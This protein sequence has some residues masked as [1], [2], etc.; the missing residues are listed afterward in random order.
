MA[1]LNNLYPPIVDT[2]APAFL[3]DSASS[4]KNTC[5]IYFSISLYNSYSDIKNAQITICNQ[6][7]NASVLNEEK[8]P[9]DIML[10][11]IYEDRER[12]SDDKYYVEI[13]KSDMINETFEINQYYKVQIRFTSIDAE[14]INIS[15]PQAIDSWLAANQG[16]FSEWSTICLVRGISTPTISIPGFD[17][18]AD[19][20]IWTTDSINVAGKVTFLNE[21]ETETLKSYRILLYNDLDELISDSDLI[22]TNNYVNVNEINYIFKY[23]FQDGETYHMTIEYTTNNLYSDSTTFTFMV[24][25]GTTGKM[26]ATLTAVEDIENGRIGINIKSNTVDKFTGNLTIRRTSSENNFTQW[27]DIYTFSIENQILDITWYDTTIKSGVWYKYCAQK[28]DSLGNRGVITKLDEPVMIVFDHMYLNAE[29]EQLNIKFNPQISSFKYVVSESVTTT[30]GSKYPFVKRNG[31]TYYRQFPISGLIS[32]LS[33][34]DGLMT[35]KEE[36]YQDTL[37]LYNEYNEKNRITILNDYT[38]ERNFREKVMEFLYKDNIKLFRSPTEGNILVKITD[39]NFTPNQTLGRML[40]T[41]SC[42]ANEIADFTMENC[43]LYNIQSL[44]QIDSELAYI[45]NFMGQFNEVVPAGTD[46]LNLL[47]EKY[48]KF[49]K[50]GFICSVD[51]LDFLRIEMEQ[52][53][54]LI[55]EGADGPYPIDDIYPDV[56]EQPASAYLGY[57]VYINGEPIVINPEGIY[58]LKGEGIKITSL[59]FPT[60]TQL[61]IQYHVSVSQTE[62]KS[63]L[64]RTIEYTKK[65]GQKWGAF[66]YKDSIFQAIWN[67]YYEKYSTYIQSLLSL[68][69]I[70]IEA[71]PGTVVYVAESRET[72]FEKHIIGETCTLSFDDKDTTIIG[73]YFAGIHFEEATNYEKMRDLLPNYRY[74]NTGITINSLDE[75]INPIKN[76]VYTL[77]KSNSNSLNNISNEENTIDKIQETKNKVYSSLLTKVYDNKFIEVLANDLTENQYIWYNDKWW[78]FT[79]SHDLLCP[80]EALIDYTC[81]ISKGWYAI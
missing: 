33:D 69:N 77:N 28:R 38:Y 43:N 6:N 22:Y 53:P 60:D 23:A 64:P 5:R 7:T 79:D 62:D 4:S 3:V 16:Y 20:T 44:G 72:E 21:E 46:V 65:V 68:D 18:A 10:T 30:I 49:M 75:V 58:E 45:E 78:L 42:T 74:I 66:E 25:L 59:V 27:E 80:V 56:D 54:Y 31:Y 19:Y 40:Y 14:N 57:I 50:E 13:K 55:K 8:Y 52:E 73:L 71:E 34:L 24:I 29:N 37:E 2:Y 26:D 32:C 9:S 12:E 48:N 11:N 41:F 47:Q 76:G 61:N 67:K 17:T 70:K 81:E 36:I 1:I 51:Y 15:T 35:T 39:I 63:Q